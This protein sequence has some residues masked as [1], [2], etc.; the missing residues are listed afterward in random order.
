MNPFA[1]RFALS[2]LAYGP[3]E[4]SVDELVRSGLRGWLE[5]QLHPDDSVDVA[6]AR[7]SAEL[8][9]RIRYGETKDWPA[10]D[11]TRSMQWLDA[12]IEKLFTLNDP[13][14]PVANQ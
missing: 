13:G 4:A 11:E 7:R 5:T 10:I 1:D 12:P 9:L 3:D 8:K 6:Y 2:R 14:K